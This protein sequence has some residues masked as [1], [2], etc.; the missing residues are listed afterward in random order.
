MKLSNNRRKLIEGAIIKAATVSRKASG[1]YFVSLRLEY[2]QEVKKRN[3]DA[4]QSIGLDFSMAHFYVDNKGKK[5]NFPY[6]II[7]TVD[8]ISKVDRKISRQT[9]DSNQREK[10]KKKRALLY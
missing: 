9:K 6:Y 4:I 3:N 5:A 10:S 7:K 1:K 8:K 2:E